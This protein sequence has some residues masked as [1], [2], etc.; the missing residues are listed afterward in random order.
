MTL[1]L[2]I[3]KFRMKIEIKKIS[4]SRILFMLNAKEIE[5]ENN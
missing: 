2:V 5:V 1:K 3:M 4:K